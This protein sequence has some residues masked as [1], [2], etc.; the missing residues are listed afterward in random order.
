MSIRSKTIKPNSLNNRS[1]VI[2][3]KRFI[4]G[5]YETQFV[6]S[7]FIDGDKHFVYDRP[8]PA[9]SWTINHRLNKEPSVT[10]V[11]MNGEIVYADVRIIDKSSIEIIFST[12]FIGKVYLN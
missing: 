5:K 11:A 9:T 3:V 4:N 12:P 2:P 7:D 6:A 1:D 8:T 10:I